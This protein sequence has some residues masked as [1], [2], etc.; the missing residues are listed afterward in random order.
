MGTDPIY[1][2]SQMR[3]MGSVPNFPNFPKIGL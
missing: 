2:Q 3:K 1:L